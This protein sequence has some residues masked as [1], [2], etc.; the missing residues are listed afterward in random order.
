MRV[1]LSLASTPPPRLSEDI[2]REVV[3]ATCLAA[4]PTVFQRKGKGVRLEVAIVDDR[5]IQ[6]LNRTYRGKD[7]PTDVLSFGDFES[8]QS[9]KLAQSATL[10]LG[11]LVL[12]HPFIDRSAKEDGVSWER[13]F[14][15]V[16]SHGVLHLLGFD[17]EEEM[18]TLQD[19]ITDQFAPLEK[20]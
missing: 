8:R 10:D 19:R 4:F 15:Y 14:M 3:K 20:K 6:E 5:E 13:E 17:H 11:T 12:S 1:I 9:V 7:K 16:F 18:F 2:L